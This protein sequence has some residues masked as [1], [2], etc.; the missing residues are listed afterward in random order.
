MIDRVGDPERVIVNNRAD[1]A[2]LAGAAGVH[3]PEHG[4]DP[5]DVRRAFPDLM[6]GASRH[7]RGGIERAEREGVDYVLVGP[8]FATPGK[9]HV[10]AG[11]LSSLCAGLRVPVVVVGG[12]TRDSTPRLAGLR[13]AG[14]A[15][16]RPFEHLETAR[17][18]ASDLVGSLSSWSGPV[19]EA[20][21]FRTP[22]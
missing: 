21:S 7:D 4:L 6:I 3:L 16:I 10:G 2:R 9:E 8:V 14:V 5:A 18:A 11:A 13:L 20:L 15:A 17:T 19:D 12:M 1:V 22:R